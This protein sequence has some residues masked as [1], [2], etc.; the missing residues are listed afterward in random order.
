MSFGTRLK[1]LLVEHEMTQNDLAR[2]LHLA[3]GTVSGYVNDSHMPDAAMLDKIA[4]MFDV[5]LDD[6]L[7]RTRPQ[8]GELIEIKGPPADLPPDIMAEFL[9]LPEESRQV[10]VHAKGKLSPEDWRA[11]ARVIQ[12]LVDEFAA[13]GKLDP[14]PPDR[15]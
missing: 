1:R 9:A 5:S 6:L 10:L 4:S 12:S 8:S 3:K 7:D 15:K 11:V 14:N 2:Y 13:K